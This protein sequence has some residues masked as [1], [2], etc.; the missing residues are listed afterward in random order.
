MSQKCITELR[1]T[2]TLCVGKLKSQDTANKAGSVAKTFHVCVQFA[3][4]A[5]LA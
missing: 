3:I 4:I 5:I 2:A 1:L